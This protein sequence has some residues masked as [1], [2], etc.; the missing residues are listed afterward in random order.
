[1][2]LIIETGAG[3]LN[4]DAYS[5]LSWI[6]DYHALQGRV[7]WAAADVLLREAAVRRGTRAIDMM[8]ADRW[9]GYRTYGRDQSLAWPRTDVITSEGDELLGDYIPIELQRAV[10]EAAWLELNQ[11]GS[12]IPSSTEQLERSISVGPIS[13]SYW[14][15]GGNSN[16]PA[17]RLEVLIPFFERFLRNI[18]MDVSADTSMQWLLRV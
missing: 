10:A 17:G 13:V 12:L 18:L 4:A 5:L 9:P 2:A 1:M 7:S 6:D 11:E 14:W 8:F 16:S 15:P 3:V